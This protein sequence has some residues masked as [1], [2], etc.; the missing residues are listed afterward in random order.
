MDLITF[1]ENFDTIAEAPSGVQRLRELILN[2]AVRG[3]LVEQDPQEDSADLLVQEIQ[4]L[5]KQAR[6]NG[7][8][9]KLKTLS[10]IDASEI[11]DDL[12]QTWLP[13]KIGDLFEIVRG[14][15]PRPKGDPKYF[16]NHQTNFHWIKISDITAYTVNN[17]LTNT[18][19]YLTEEGS[20]YSRKVNQQDIIVAASG[21]VGKSC[22]LDIE[23][24]IYDGL[25]AIKN[26]FFDELKS[27]I[28]CFFKTIELSLLNDATGT[29]WKNI[30]TDILRNTIIPLP[31][32][33]EQKRIVAKVDE[34]MGICDKIEAAQQNR[35]SLRQKLRASALDTL[36]NATTDDQLKKAWGFV[37]DRWDDLN[38]QPED[39]KEMRLL[40]SNFAIRGK[41]PTRNISDEPSFTLLDRINEKRTKL[42]KEKKI[43]KPKK[44]TPLTDDLFP[45]EIPESWIWI[46]L[47][48]V[49]KRIDY[50]TS[51]KASPNE[52]DI[53]V[54]RMGNIQSGEILFDNLKY[55]PDSIK[56]LPKLFLVD[57]D[58]LFNRTNSFELVGKSGVFRGPSNQ[59]TFASYLIRITF[60]LNYTNPDYFNIVLNSGFFR[61]TQIEPEI[62]Q[63][64]GQANFNGTKLQHTLI[65]M[66]PIQEQNRIVEQVWNFKGYCDRLENSLRQSQE[67]SSAL[68]SAAI[69]NLEV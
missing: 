35:D 6:K 63:Q 47:G 52:D 21:S 62:T 7:R 26:V 14:S 37:C 53:P 40:L 31:P 39:V 42:V 51:S 3:K 41:L 49:I 24:Y 67:K 18:I 50:G 69:A 17:Y 23:G 54:F 34:L 38:Q 57:G 66:P 60:L 46:R 10:K 5:K 64:C 4:E 2:L 44:L 45:C 59:Y 55:V 22:L 16:A 61:K 1:F 12:P 27:Y 36:M 32:L 19:E 58:I 56:D 25:M 13:V 29:S 33:A 9:K 28:L 20:K 8:S 68:A 65:P 30:N 43:S 48:Q 11:P 15:S